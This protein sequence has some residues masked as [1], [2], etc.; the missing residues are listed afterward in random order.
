MPIPAVP[1]SRVASP[2]D[3]SKRQTPFASALAD[4]TAPYTFPNTSTASPRSPKSAPGVIP[5]T[6]PK[7]WG[8]FEPGGMRQ[9]SPSGETLTK[10]DPVRPMAIPSGF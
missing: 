5:S 9:T 7:G 8:S 10:I 1:G 6:W 4:C 2:V 3:R